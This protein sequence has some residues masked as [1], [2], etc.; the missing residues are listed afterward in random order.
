MLSFLKYNIDLIM[1]LILQVN[2]HV[3]FDPSNKNLHFLVF[4]I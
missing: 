2:G 1:F 3:C 4:K